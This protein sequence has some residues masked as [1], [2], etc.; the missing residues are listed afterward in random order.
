M[1]GI[2]LWEQLPKVQQYVAQYYT[3]ALTEDQKHHQLRSYIEKYILDGGY[4]V[5][6]FADKE[7]IDRIYSE[8]VEY[9]VLTPYLGSW[10]LDE[11]NIN[12]WDDITLT[13]SD[14]RTEKLTEHFH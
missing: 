3:A 6:G 12:S 9:S 13:Y 11:V 7:L 1:T 10:D 2:D 14:G 4:A 5:E 8:M